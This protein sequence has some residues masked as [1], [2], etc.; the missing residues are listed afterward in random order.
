MHQLF[1]NLISNSI[2]YSKPDIPPVITISG[3]KTGDQF[4]E[5]LVKDNG[6]GFENKYGT[7]IFQPFQRLHGPGYEGTGIGLSICKKIVELYG[8]T[9]QVE[10]MPGEGSVFSFSLPGKPLIT[11]AH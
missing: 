10:S 3:R 8:G 5:I 6:I 7:K 9:M 2:K 4:I 11:A 1:Q